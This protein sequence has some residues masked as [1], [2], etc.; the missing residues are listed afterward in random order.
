MIVGYA[1]VSTPIT[2]KGEQALASNRQV[3]GPAGTSVYRVLE[4][5]YVKAC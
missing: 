3:G 2:S 4:A 5:G 1:R